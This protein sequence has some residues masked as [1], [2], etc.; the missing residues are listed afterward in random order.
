[1]SSAPNH[2]SEQAG[3]APGMPDQRPV[4]K[5]S[6]IKRCLSVTAVFLLTL[7]SLL[8]FTHTGN[9]L[10]WQQ[11]SNALPALDGELTEGQLMTGWHIKNLHWQDSRI[12]FQADDITLKWQ[13]GKVLTRQL[14]VQ[15]V[16]VK[17]GNLEIQPTVEETRPS[18][19]PSTDTAINIPLDILISQIHI[20]DF[21]VTFSG[22][23]V[24][25]ETFTANARIQN[26]KLFIPEVRA[27]NLQI[28]LKALTP[29]QQASAGIDLSTITLPEVKLPIPVSLENFTLTNARYQQGDIDETLK[30]LELSFNWQATY[31]TDLTLKAEQSRANILLNGEIQLAE[32]YPLSLNLDVTILDNFN[33]PEL[34]AIKGDK[35]SLEASGD[36]GQ[37][38]LRLASQ[39]SINTSLEGNIGPLAPNFPLNV[40]L[41]WHEFQWPLQEN[42]PVVSSNNGLARITGNLNQYQLSLNTSIKVA[43]QPATQLQLD[44]SGSLQQL[45]IETL[46]LSPVDESNLSE[47]PLELTGTVSWQDGIHWQ[48]HTLLSKLKPELWLRE[49][50]GTLS[51]KVTTQF[52]MTD[53]SWQ[54]NIPELTINGSLLNNPLELT[55]KLASDNQVRPMAALP[56]NVNIHSFYAAFGENRLNINGQIAEQ[57]SLSAKL[58][59][60]SLDRITPELKGSLQGSVQL[61]GSDK[62]PKLLFSFDSPSI[63]VQQTSINRLQV[64]GELTRATLLEGKTTVKA[65]SLSSGNIQLKNVL[66]NANGSERNHQISLKTQGEPVSGELQINGAWHH[67]NSRGKWQGQLASARVI[68]PVDTWSL[69]QPVTIGLN[70]T[71][72]EVKLTNQCWFAKPARLCIDASQFSA[73]R[74]TTRFRLSDFNLSTLKPLLPGNLNWQAILSGSGDIQWDSGQPIAHIQI[75]TTPGEITSNSDNPLSV[76]YQ[77]LSTVINLNE[78]DLQAEFDFDS[79]QLGDAHI[80][81]AIDNMHSDQT[82][83]GQARLQDMRLYFLQPLIPDIRHVDGILSADTRMGGTLKYPLL[84]GNLKLRAGQLAAK[85]EMVKVSHLITE[86]N[87]DGNKGEVSG[88]MKI[89]DGEMKLSGHLD[90]QQMP[91][92]GV[93]DITGQNLGAR[94]PGILQLKAS[95]DLRLTIGAAQTLTGN[96]TIPW[97]RA[98]IK[99]LPRQA[100]TPSD[101]VLI[102]TPGTRKALLHA[103][104][105]FSMD[106]NVILGKDIKID[107]YGLKSDL[108]GQLLLDLQPGKPMTADGSIQL[109]NGRY[110]QFGQ[111]LLIKEGHIIFSGPLSSPYLSVNAIRNPDSIEDDVSVG[112][113]V[114]GAPSRPEFSIYSDPSMPQQEQWSYLLRGRGL[115]DGDSSAV[116]SML[117]GFGVSQF[118]GVVTS[119]GE[120]IGLSDVTLDTQ[121]SG[122]DTRVTIGGTIAPGLRV[123]Y[124]AGV[125]DSIAEVKVRYELMP[126]LYLQAVSG[127]AQA[128]DLFYQFTI[129]TEKK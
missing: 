98:N 83:S 19:P 97:A 36:L 82:L 123:Q 16:A 50:P 26:S 28:V 89:D 100:V 115:E 125:F 67:D 23:T 24:S 77:T 14:P 61:S 22:T 8:L 90:W 102:I 109:T 3:S 52:M 44:A 118:G 65:D 114:S 71:N 4:K 96:I 13:P 55:G 94:V 117:I 20:Q 105:P 108:G 85:Q 95:P 6:L 116:Q 34:A 74:G 68:T 70:A 87:V 86:L 27:D 31:I 78:D 17:G 9:T 57:L 88:S 47:K 10:L 56:F 75:Q 124:G 48:G 32:N 104:P 72:K 51:G 101:D 49:L 76:N 122:D 121:G 58:D 99:Q 12:K 1:M 42:A 80:H 21:E 79:K 5:V 92:S 37:L 93:I 29:N 91:P 39:D 111:D 106:V 33:M 129:A 66:L 110:H 81:L 127:I 35:L 2:N 45:T 113:Q 53:G 15:L 18:A 41:K 60:S 119:I 84:F 40:A 103:G 62:H 128:I 120:K 59:A 107:A 25:L 38:Q 63:E 64:N 46:S 54:L 126:R 11:L 73:N 30:A 7:I 112:M 69:E 43:E